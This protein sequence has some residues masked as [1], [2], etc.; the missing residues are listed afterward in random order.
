MAHE[1]ANLL[2]KLFLEVYRP[3]WE[4]KTT[5]RVLEQGSGGVS[6]YRNMFTPEFEY[7]DYELENGSP[8]L[9]LPYESETFDVVISNSVFEHDTMF[10]LSFNELIRVLKPDGLLFITTPSNGPFH[11]YP[12]DCWRFYPDSAGALVNWARHC[13]Y[14]NVQLVESFTTEKYNDYWCDYVMV[15]IK[16][17]QHA[18]QYP[19]RM[20]HN[21]SWSGITNA[22]VLGANSLINYQHLPQDQRQIPQPIAVFPVELQIK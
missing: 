18:D 20:A 9:T 17:E 10:W 15:I 22:S 6:D 21:V 3:G 19:K 14:A 16:D 7:S 11:R 5:K 2:N 13:G 4:N 1:S 12:V 8:V